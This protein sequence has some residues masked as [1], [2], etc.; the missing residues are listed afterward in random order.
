M[1]VIV[2]CPR[3]GG[4]LTCEFEYGEP[5]TYDYPGSPS[6]WY[7]INDPVSIAVSEF[8]EITCVHDGAFTKEEEAKFQELCD[9][10]ASE[11]IEAHELQELP[12]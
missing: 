2:P 12:F 3:C 5:R 6:Y 9:N 10:A 7:S 8:E 1:Q 11:Q 4:E